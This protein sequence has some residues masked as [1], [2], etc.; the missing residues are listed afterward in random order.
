MP[1]MF[2]SPTSFRNLVTTSSNLS[3]PDSTHAICRMVWE[4]ICLPAPRATA[5]NGGFAL[6]I[7]LSPGVSRTGTLRCISILAAA[8]ELM[9]LG[10]RLGVGIAED[11]AGV[12][13][14][15]ADC[16]GMVMVSWHD[17]H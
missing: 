1:M 9:A 11:D 3:W 12:G 16:A 4:R 8:D 13:A 2:G 6:T 7:S 17:G 5:S 10:A 15:F 14:L